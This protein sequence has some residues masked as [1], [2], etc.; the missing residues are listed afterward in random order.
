VM[1][2]GKIVEQGSAEQVLRSPQNDYTRSLLAAVP[3]VDVSGMEKMIVS[4]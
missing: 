3:R 2:L 1:Y 4:A